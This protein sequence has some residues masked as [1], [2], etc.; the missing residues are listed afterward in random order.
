MASTVTLLG[1]PLFVRVECDID[2]YVATTINGRRCIGVIDS[3]QG[4]C[5]VSV[6]FNDAEDHAAYGFYYVD[7]A[8]IEPLTDEELEDLE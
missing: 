5:G 3:F 7:F 2:D 1:G 8:D 6:F 4:P